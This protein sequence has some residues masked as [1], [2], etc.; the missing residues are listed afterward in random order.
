MLAHQLK[1]KGN[2]VI[3][4]WLSIVLDSF[5]DFGALDVSQCPEG[6]RMFAIDQKPTN[7]YI[8]G[9]LFSSQDFPKIKD[10]YVNYWYC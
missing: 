7:N 2:V 4:L 10:I 9:K 8:A 1:V 5:I 3:W 6:L